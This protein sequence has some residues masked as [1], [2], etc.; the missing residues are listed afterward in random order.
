[1]DTD[2]RTAMEDRKTGKRYFHI[3]YR[4]YAQGIC[5]GKVGQSFAT[6][7]GSFFSYQACEDKILNQLKGQGYVEK[8]GKI[9][10]E[11]ILFHEFDN[12]KDWLAFREV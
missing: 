2:T 9:E 10:A 11:M 1:M 8:F 4:I 5:I 3:Q 7:N 12:E 6:E